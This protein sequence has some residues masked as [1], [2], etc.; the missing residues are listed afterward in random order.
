MVSDNA[1]EDD[2]AQVCARFAERLDLRLYRQAEDV[3]AERNVVSALRAAR[4]RYCVY[5]GDD[6]RLDLDAIARVVALFE[7]NT[8]LVCVQA[9]WQ[10]RDDAHQRDLG[11]F[12]SV[13][14]PAAFTADQAWPCWQFLLHNR[15]FPEIGV[16]RTADLH[17]VLH[18]PSSVHWAFV[19]CFR[20]L[21]RGTVA[22]L[23]VPFYIH[24]VRPAVDL[25]PRTQLGVQQSTTHLDRYR[26]GLE[27][28]LA[29]AL[30]RVVGHVPEEHRHKAMLALDR[31]MAERA[32][33]AARVAASQG[34]FVG[35]IEHFTRSRVWNAG[36]DRQALQRFEQEHTM[37]AGLQA[38]VDTAR[39]SAG[40]TRIL[41]DA[42]DNTERVAA[43]LGQVF[44][45][46]GEVVIDGMIQEADVVLVM[47]PEHREAA[48][49]RGALP[50][51]VLV[52]EELVDCFRV[53]NV[54][55][56]IARTRP[57]SAA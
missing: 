13:S 16:Y 41:L 32:A 8:S 6:D 30:R 52:W 28:S 5:L 26:G 34:D 36:V 29:A 24:V 53:H 17:P 7:E 47:R 2:T 4:G 45:W 18:L 22:F 44:G 23:S 55:G 57:G 49:A 15:V 54:L 35:A 25:P 19:W 33:V 51:R 1:S 14:E 46:E 3:G 27:W 31:F 10:T 11:L 56:A 48:V 12:Y 37:L 38:L 50:G 20:L 21:G 9:P 42:V 39:A 43:L 40:C